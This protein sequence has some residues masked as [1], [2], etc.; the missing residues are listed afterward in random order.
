MASVSGVLGECQ[1]FRNL[2][3]P[4]AVEI[5]TEMEKKDGRYDECDAYCSWR[6][7]EP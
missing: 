5:V 2:E 1:Y 3:D 4:A 7:A 6:P